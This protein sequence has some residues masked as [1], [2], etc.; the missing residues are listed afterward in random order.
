VT[1]IS[2]GTSPLT[3]AE[4]LQ[5]VNE[6]FDLRPGAL[7]KFVKVFHIKYTFSRFQGTRLETTHLFTNRSQWSFWSCGLP[8]GAAERAANCTWAGRQVGQ[9][10]KKAATTEHGTIVQWSFQALA[11][12]APKNYMMDENG[13]S[14]V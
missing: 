11:W 13:N 3:E 7:I 2:Y 14:C 8:L 4:L 12:I 6:N 10:P 9:L 5:V 1:V